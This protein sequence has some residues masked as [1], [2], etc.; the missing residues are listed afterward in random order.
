MTPKVFLFFSLFF[1]HNTL[2]S[3]V[4]LTRS[5][6]IQLALHLEAADTSLQYDFSRIALLEMLLTYEQELLRAQESLTTLPHSSIRNKAQKRAKIISWQLG[7]RNYIK[8]LENYLFSLDSG[9]SVGFMISHQEKII[10]LIGEQPVIISGPNSGS[11]KQIENNIVEQFCL[12]YDCREYFLKPQLNKPSENENTQS[13]NTDSLLKD[14]LGRWNIY[15]NMEADFIYNNGISF[16]FN[17]IKDRKNKEKWMSGIVNELLILTD[18][19]KI[20][21]EK[22]N[23]IQWDSL[24]LM[25]LPLTD[26]AQKIILNKQMDFIK[27]QI[28]LLASNK[29]LFDLLKPWI[30]SIFKEKNKFR[31]IIKQADS[32]Y[33]N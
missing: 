11:D 7:T 24:T 17:S 3:E 10:V 1:F 4:N 13:T 33:S 26:N 32:Y 8:T 25:E 18:K 16:Q 28:P 23:S 14:T 30:Q 29:D 6:L 15:S 27:I 5:K 21:E 19:L 9:V 2:A 20:A 12:T 31:I 22:G